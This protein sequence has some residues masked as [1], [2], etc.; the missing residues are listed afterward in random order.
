M[1]LGF[2]NINHDISIKQPITFYG[3]ANIILRF[4]ITTIIRECNSILYNLTKVTCR[5][6]RQS[7]SGVKLFVLCYLMRL[8]NQFSK[9]KSIKRVPFYKVKVKF[10]FNPYPAEFLKKGQCT[11]H[12]LELSII[13]FWGYQDENLEF[14]Y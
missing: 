9:K 12:I 3:N 13:D 4:R 1:T 10:Q 11:F 14:N 8:N 7:V 5:C 6:Y 2:L